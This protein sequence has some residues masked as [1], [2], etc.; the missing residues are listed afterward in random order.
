ML[1]K[2]KLRHKELRNAVHTVELNMVNK[3]VFFC[4]CFCLFLSDIICTYSALKVFYFF[5]TED[6]ITHLHIKIII[7]NIYLIVPRIMQ[8]L[9]F[10]NIL[11]LIPRETLYGECQKTFTQKRFKSRE[12]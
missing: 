1:S 9:L 6:T 11:Q 10:R 12:M 7:E 3:N 2:L 4:V 5:L 8:N